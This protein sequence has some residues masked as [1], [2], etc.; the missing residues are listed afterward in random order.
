MSAHVFP[1]SEHSPKT[2]RECTHE[3]AQ[4]LHWLLAEREWR[5]EE[6]RKTLWA[7]EGAQRQAELDL[8]RQRNGVTLAIHQAVVGSASGLRRAIL[9]LHHPVRDDPDEPDC[10]ECSDDYGIPFPC[11]TYVL[12]RDWEDES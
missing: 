9:E 11:D 1:A 3:E 7:A 4:L 6:A 5:V 8:K 10:K 2:A 12:A